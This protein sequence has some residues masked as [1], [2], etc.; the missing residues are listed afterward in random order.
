M[1]GDLEAA[2]FVV[3]DQKSTW[4]PAKKINWLGIT[5]FCESDTIAIK[6]S[7]IVKA[8]NTIECLLSKMQVSALELSLFVGSIA[9]LGRLSCIMTLSDSD[10]CV[11]E[12]G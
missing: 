1:R 4:T 2:G 7:R 6:Q 9:V 11:V 5:W 12:L 3:N 10:C 8:V